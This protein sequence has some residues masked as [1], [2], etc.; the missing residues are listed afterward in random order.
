MRLRWAEWLPPSLGGRI[1]ALQAA[2]VVAVLVVGTL[3]AVEWTQRERDAARADLAG[4]AVHDAML[5]ALDGRAPSGEFGSST[6]VVRPGHGPLPAGFAVQQRLPAPP[7]PPSTLVPSEVTLWLKAGG[8]GERALAALDEAATARTYFTLL[9]R[10][11]VALNRE[12]LL[13]V[14]LPQGPGVLRREVMAL[15]FESPSLWRDRMPPVSVLLGALAALGTVFVALGVAARAL[16]QPIHT[17]A[18][19]IDARGED[20][21]VPLLPE[22]GPVE[23]RAMARADNR[24]RT[25]LASVLADQTR[26]LAAVSH[27]LRTP[28]TRLRLRAELVAD[29]ELR[30]AMLRDLDD[31]DAMLTEVLDFL[32]HEVREEPVKA[33]DLTALLQSVCDDYA[34]LG[35]PVTFCE[36]P[37]LTFHGVPT[38]F[39]STQQTHVFQHERKVRHSCRPNA[40]RRALC[41]LI[42]NALKYG[43]RADVRLDAGGDAVRI[44]VHDTGP[45]IPEDEME[46]VFLPLYRLESSRQRSTGGIGLGLAIVKA[47]VAA[48]HG[49][50]ELRNRPE[51]GLV[52][53]LEL[54]RSLA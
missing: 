38:L 11:Q 6:V 8:L 53:S 37:P 45:G 12:S 54:P 52:V 32:S 1:L 18:S 21:Q 48:H 42:D 51:G 43:H 30:E 13:V 34:D 24:L 7:S 14:T 17:L 19:S 46:K 44:A 26:M 36:P 3:C 50:I 5:Q 20:V 25:R 23:A 31:M 47:V 16:A 28:S 27:D 29:V 49:R 22:A 10:E 9:S 41:N 39:A 2:G 4:W 40:L 33:V 15:R 35:R